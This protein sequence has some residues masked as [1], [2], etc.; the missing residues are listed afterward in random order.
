[1][2]S[3]KLMDGLI[4]ESGCAG[5]EGCCPSKNIK[6]TMKTAGKLIRWDDNKKEKDFLVTIRGSGGT[7]VG[8]FL[9]NLGLFLTISFALCTILINHA[10]TP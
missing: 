6:P 5:E 8:V 1:M 3:G 2:E 10:M 9:K 4:M 7:K